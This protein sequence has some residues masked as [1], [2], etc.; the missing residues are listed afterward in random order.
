MQEKGKLDKAIAYYEKALSFKSD[1]AEA[2]NNMGIALKDQGKLD[3][4]ILSY[5]RRSI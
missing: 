2:C 4:A 3:E 5:E 1:F